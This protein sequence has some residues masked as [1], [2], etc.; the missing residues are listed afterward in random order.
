ME[1]KSLKYNLQAHRTLIND[2]R[3]WNHSL[4][5][6]LRETKSILKEQSRN[7]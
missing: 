4:E 3:D 5:K 2:L 7:N 6:E 1:L